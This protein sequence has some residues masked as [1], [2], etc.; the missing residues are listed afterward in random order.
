MDF[1]LE[2]SLVVPDYPIWRFSVGQYHEMIRAG[3]LTEDDPVELLEGW[4]VT[5]MPKNPPHT[6]ATQL[7]REALG[8]IVPSGWHVTDQEPITATDS[9][10]EPDVVVV[11]GSLRDYSERHPSPSDIALVVEVSDATLQRDRTL[12]L[13]VYANA[14]ITAYWILNLPERQLEAYSDPADATY[15]QQLIYRESDAVPVVLDDQEIGRIPV[16]DV[17]P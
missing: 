1:T 5:K 3:F 14:R 10:P 11:R 9:E 17:L 6:L 15:R 7:T 4:L 8:R 16:G 2:E 13:R 12:K